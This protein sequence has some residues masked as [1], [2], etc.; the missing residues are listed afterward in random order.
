MKIL[1]MILLGFVFGN[2]KSFDSRL[3]IYLHDKLSSYEKY[4]YEILRLP[5]NERLEIDT[6]KNFRM[7]GEYAYVPV[8]IYDSKKNASHSIITLRVKLYKNVL[9]SKQKIDRDESLSPSMFDKKLMDVS[10][11]EGD[12]VEENALKDCRSKIIINEKTVLFQSMIEPIPVISRGEKVTIHTGGNGVDVS[13]EGIAR[14][15]GLIDQVISVQC[16][17]QIFKAKV[18]DKYNLSLVE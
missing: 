17:S 1:M 4:E 10:R 7:S 18:I 16:R 13:V 6:D 2:G 9:V 5:Q 12:L 8:K 15:D 11:M 3:K 14:Q